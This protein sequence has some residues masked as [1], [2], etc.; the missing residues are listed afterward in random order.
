MTHIKSV[1][2]KVQMFDQIAVQYDKTTDF[3][4]YQDKKW[5][6]QLGNYLPTHP[7]Q[8]VDLAMQ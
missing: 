8:I 2:I 3:S 6:R 7:L 5:R 1:D 4:L